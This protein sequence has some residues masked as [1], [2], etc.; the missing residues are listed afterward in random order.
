MSQTQPASNAGTTH[1]VG[2]GGSASK[3]PHT[4]APIPDY[5]LVISNTCGACKK[6]RETFLP[7]KNQVI[8]YHARPSKLDE[9]T[10]SAL[11]NIKSVPA[12]VYPKLRKV[13]VGVKSKAEV[14]AKL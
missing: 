14:E 8:D 7:P 4:H 2:G 12:W 5:Y 10:E 3:S 1:T 6:Q 9:Y 11:D 13:E